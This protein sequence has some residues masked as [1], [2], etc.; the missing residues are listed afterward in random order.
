MRYRWG[1]A[2][3]VLTI[4]AAG[5]GVASAG[6][7][8]FGAVPS[9][10]ATA[11]AAPAVRATD[12][13]DP[14][15]VAAVAKWVTNGGGD[16]LNAL[17]S[18]FSALEKAANANDLAQMSLGCQQ[19]QTDV[20]AA[21]AHAPIPDKKAEAA[22]SLALAKYARGATDCAA[23]ADTSNVTLIRK[24][25]NEIIDGSNDLDKVT[26]RLNEIAG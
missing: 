15:L 5:I 25:S 13:P 9:H 8:V 20:E 7:A 12:P 14:K 21:Q 10:V 3:T 19:L 2:I 1:K 4:G 26:A 22:W 6:T 24:A 17:G 23:G 11:N 16:D 18:D